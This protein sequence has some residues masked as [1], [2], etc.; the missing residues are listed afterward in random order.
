[1]SAR[2]AVV[3]TGI[4]NL[5]SVTKALEAVGA[6]PLVVR[7]PPELDEAGA[8]G[9]ILPG[10]GALRDCVLSL[11][12]SKLDAT[13]KEWISLDRPF[14]GVCLGMQALFDESEEGGVT[15]LG[16]FAGR[17]V[18]F[19]L[20]PPLKV[21]HMGWNTIRFTQEGSSLQDGLADEGESF[22]FV[23]SYH[24]VPEDRGL[25]LAECDYGSPFVAA[26]GR[27]RMFATQFHPEKSQTKG[28]RI[29]R[30]FAASATAPLIHR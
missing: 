23:H 16:V 25:V 1:M 26:I 7:T 28:L 20:A 17:V 9:L 4:C 3:D 2:I 30:N 13:V 22:Y 24:C 10:V 8:D 14:L 19:R 27:G 11:R 29:Y 21:P 12:S 6:S 15:G 5:R 18:R